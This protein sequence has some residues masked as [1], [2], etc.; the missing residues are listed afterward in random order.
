[1]VL[2]RRRVLTRGYGATSAEEAQDTLYSAGPIPL[3]VCAVRYGPM[4]QL[5]DVRYRPTRQLCAVQRRRCGTSLG[6]RYGKSGT[7][8]G[9]NVD[10]C[11]LRRACR[12]RCAGAAMCLRARYA[13]P[14]TDGAYAATSQQNK[15]I[16]ACFAQ[17]HLY[18]YQRCPLYCPTHLLCAH[19]P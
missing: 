19:L 1:M 18:R 16:A 17:G 2:P 10:R 11:A 7:D 9:D 6:A 12:A 3:H 14:G 4:V 5:C 15:G 13:M 8:L